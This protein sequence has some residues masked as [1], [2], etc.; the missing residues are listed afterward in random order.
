[1]DSWSSF[2]LFGI[3]K[4]VLFLKFELLMLWISIGDKVFIY[5]LYIRLF[6]SLFI[7]F[8]IGWWE[9]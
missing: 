2:G 9:I 6:D 3:V 7:V 1:M 8:Y 4:L 5:G